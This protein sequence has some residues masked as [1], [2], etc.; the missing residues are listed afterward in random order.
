MVS[1]VS[2]E[3]LR[4]R[5]CGSARRVV[6][7]VGSGVLTKDD[8]LNTRTVTRLVN[9][10]AACKSEGR[11]IVMVSSGAIASGFKKIGLKERPKT[12][13]DKQAC[14]A[15]GQSSLIHSYETAFDRHGYKVAQILLT[16]DDLSHRRRYL[17]ARN[18]LNTLLAWD[19]VP[20]INEN[21]TV[22]VAEIKFGD[23]DTLAGMITGL[24]EADLLINLTD[25]DGL[26]DSDP[27]RNPEARFM[28]LIET[29]GPR[30]EAMA[31]NIPGAL[32]SGGMYTKVVA[33]RR[34]AR[35]GVPT[36]IA[37]GARPGTLMAVLSGENTGTLFLP[38]DKT[39][40]QKKHW[41]AFTAKPRGSLVVDDGARRA[42]LDRGKSLLPSGVV[43]V[44][45][46]FNLGDSVQIQDKAG[47]LV[48]VGLTNYSSDEM[49]RIIGCQSCDIEKVLGH[50][51]ADEVVHRDNMV[52]GKDLKF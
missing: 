46:H 52:V 31:S 23:N 20:I 15:V 36:V 27:R 5:F 30:I 41:I 47:K 8:G 48:A 51:H 1:A 4:R 11:Q 34:L 26:Y 17:N 13:Q 28:S 40:S 22:V 38:R 9:E 12:I 19:I 42:L 16:A 14:A 25:I 18:T 35:R 37:N 3:E 24:V 45:D 6:V 32:G 39:L 50:K 2:E 10:I 43:Q 7:K 49:V 33:A 44:I 21:D 29:V